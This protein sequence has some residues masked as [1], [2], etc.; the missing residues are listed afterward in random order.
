TRGSETFFNTSTTSNVT[1]K[2]LTADIAM[3][4]GSEGKGLWEIIAAFVGDYDF[5]QTALSGNVAVKLANDKATVVSKIGLSKLTVSAPG[6]PAVRPLDIAVNLNAE[7]DLK[8]TITKVASFSVAGTDGAT[9]F[10]DLSLDNPI[11]IDASGKEPTANDFAISATLHPLGLDFVAPFAKDAGVS[12][13]AGTVAT[14][15]KIGV[16]GLG[17]S[18]SVKGDATL[19]N[20]MAKVAG[21]GELAKPITASTTLDIGFVDFKTL[22]VQSLKTDVGDGST[23]LAKVTVGGK[24]QVPLGL[25]LTDL[26]VTVADQV[27]A[28]ALLALWKAEESAESASQESAPTSEEP[29]AEF[30]DI[31]VEAAVSVSEVRYG[32]IIAKDIQTNVVIKDRKATLNNT[33]LKLNDGSIA[34]TGAA[35]LSDMK[36]LAF[37]G[38]ADIQ[39]IQFAPLIKTFSPESP[40]KIGG[41]L[42]AFKADFS[43]TGTAWEQLSK[44]LLADAEFALDSLT[45]QQSADSKLTQAVALLLTTVGLN[46]ED[47]T[48]AD[49]NGS[50]TAKDGTLNI[51]PLQLTAHELRLNSTGSLNMLNWEP[52]LKFGIAAADG[53]A[54]RLEKKSI[55]LRPITGDTRFKSAPDF[56]VYGPMDPA[57]L[58][59]TVVWEYTKSYAQNALINKIS[60][61]S[62]EAAAIFGGLTDALNNRSK[63][64]GTDGKPANG[65]KE[66]GGLGGLIGAGLNA[67]GG[68]QQNPDAKP[69]AP[70][71]KDTTAPATAPKEKAP[72]SDAS[73]LLGAGLKIFGAVQQQKEREKAD[74]EAKEKPA[75]PEEK[76]PP[77][78]T[79][80]DVLKLFR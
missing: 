28:D 70:T 8:K 71:A 57:A 65:E 46:W 79:V 55:P 44:S 4:L 36:A 2:P 6:V 17:K 27:D 24:M 19:A 1:V 74:E 16:G 10:L 20:V 5:G 48:F 75:E 11:S 56:K 67:L 39:N 49:G 14:S 34:I 13:L 64:K 21:S 80:N 47:M 76:A 32:E 29:A 60:E 45:L 77:A 40:F 35:D 68:Q 51:N 7:Q 43:G 18:L 61:Q 72:A 78:P 9:P 53:L 41:G 58:T 31:W 37:N 26:T 30:P 63:N 25:E 50:L 15:L 62:P 23:S 22:T 69:P 52:D 59:K 66:G 12:G 33:S 3:T 54:R 42:K 73:N 38:D